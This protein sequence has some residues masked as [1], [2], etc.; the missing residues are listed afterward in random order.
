MRRSIRHHN[1]NQ[2]RLG[3]VLVET[4]F[5]VPILTMLTFGSIEFG[6]AFMVSN[7]LTNAAREGARIGIISGTTTQEVRNAVKQHVLDTIGATIQDSDITVDVT[8]YGTNPD[9]LD[10]TA[11]AS[12][13]DL[14][15]VEVVVSYNNVGYFFRYLTGV[16]L[17]GQAAMR[18]E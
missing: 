12:K 4:A 7:L 17:R 6:R 11:N 16:N 9:P 8:P 18:H 14:V 3:A 5:V 1:E 2:S 15:E 10:E 13:R